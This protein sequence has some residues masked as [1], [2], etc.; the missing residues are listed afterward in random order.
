MTHLA[1]GPR[2]QCVLKSRRCRLNGFTTLMTCRAPTSNR[3]NTS[4]ANWNTDCGPDLI[5]PPQE[6]RA[7]PHRASCCR[8][9]VWCGSICCYAN[10]ANRV[11][12]LMLTGPPDGG[13]FPLQDNAACHTTQNAQEL[14]DE[15]INEL[16]ARC[17]LHGSDM[18]RQG[19]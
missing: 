15:K 16:A 11:H 14:P 8:R 9:V 7:S 6:I 4:G 12:T 1:T 17:S 10:L 5:P 19:N 18:V 3:C 2:S 13:G